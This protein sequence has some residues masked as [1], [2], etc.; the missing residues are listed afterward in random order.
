[1][2]FFVSYYYFLRERAS[3]TQASYITLYPLSPGTNISIA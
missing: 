2:D 3:H 1:M